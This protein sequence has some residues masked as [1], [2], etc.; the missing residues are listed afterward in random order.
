[1]RI[2]FICWCEDGI[3]PEGLVQLAGDGDACHFLEQRCAVVGWRAKGRSSC[4]CWLGTAG[5][6]RRDGWLAVGDQNKTEQKRQAAKN[7]KDQDENSL[8]VVN[9]SNQYH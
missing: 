7:T 2:V 9:G 3:T 5:E 6:V 1:M 8:Q 4:C